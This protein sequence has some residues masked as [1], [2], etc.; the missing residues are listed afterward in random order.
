MAKLP[1]HNSQECYLAN[2][3]DQSPNIGCILKPMG[4]RPVIWEVPRGK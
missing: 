3:S 1:D 2:L 4:D